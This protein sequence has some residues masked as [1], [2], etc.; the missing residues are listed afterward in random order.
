MKTYTYHADGEASGGR[1]EQN[2]FGVIALVDAHH[3]DARR[4]V[5]QANAA[6]QMRTDL[7]WIISRLE[8]GGKAAVSDAIAQAKHAKARGEA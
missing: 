6:L 7:D 1:I 4:L 5:Y 8:R 2:G 3:D